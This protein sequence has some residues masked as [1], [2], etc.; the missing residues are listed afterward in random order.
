MQCQSLIEGLSEVSSHSTVSFHKKTDKGLKKCA[1]G[2]T[3][4]KDKP[5]PVLKSGK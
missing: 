2:I 3:E 5:K 4:D 1:A